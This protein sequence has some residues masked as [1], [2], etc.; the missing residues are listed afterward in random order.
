M[1]TGDF[2]KILLSEPMSLR[3]CSVCGVCQSIWHI[4]GKNF[5]IPFGDGENEPGKLQDL[6]LG[7]HNFNKLCERK[8]RS[9]SVLLQIFCC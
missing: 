8:S 7:W 1:W 6:S 2:L 9:I 4:L 5:D 3:P